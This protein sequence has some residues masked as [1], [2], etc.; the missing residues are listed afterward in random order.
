MQEVEKISGCMQTDNA[1]I[2]LTEDT[3]ENP[4]RHSKMTESVSF[5]SEDLCVGIV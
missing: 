1:S 2:E 4:S 3:N 5:Q